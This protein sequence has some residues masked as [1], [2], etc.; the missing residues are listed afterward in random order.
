MII[1]LCKKRGILVKHEFVSLW[2]FLWLLNLS[3]SEKRLPLLGFVCFHRVIKE[4]SD[5]SGLQRFSTPITLISLPLRPKFEGEA[6]FG[7]GM[8]VWCVRG[9]AEVWCHSSQFNVTDLRAS[10]QRVKLPPCYSL[11]VAIR[12]FVCTLCYKF[13]GAEVVRAAASLFIPYRQ[14]VAVCGIFSQVC[15]VTLEPENLATE[16]NEKSF[17]LEHGYVISATSAQPNQLHFPLLGKGINA[18]V[19][20]LML[21]GEAAS[22]LTSDRPVVCSLTNHNYS[23]RLLSN[24]SREEQPLSLPPSQLRFWRLRWLKRQRAIRLYLHK[25]RHLYWGYVKWRKNC[26][27]RMT[28]PAFR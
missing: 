16:Q 2:F 22:V 24:K 13:M 4:R 14:S 27:S 18:G 26:S 7:E 10:W 12:Q 15:D 28:R 25:V 8:R 17:F 23:W 20:K 6:E 9:A 11:Q 5:S 1:R 21:A 3:L 19:K